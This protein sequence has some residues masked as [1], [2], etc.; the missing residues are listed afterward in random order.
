MR[1]AAHLDPG[2]V[3][4]YNAHVV[5]DDTFPQVLPPDVSF[6]VGGG[7]GGGKDVG[8]AEMRPEFFGNNRPAHEFGNGEQFQQ[9]G[10]GR[11][12]GIAGVGVDAVEEIGLLV[13]VR[14]KDNVINY[15][16]EDL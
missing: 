16:L 3:S 4:S 9:L 5:L 12:Q 6:G 8:G 7:R 14:G 1:E 2:V 11:D 10:F 13:I 15:S